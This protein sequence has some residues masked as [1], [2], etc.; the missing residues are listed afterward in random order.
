MQP[1]FK[2]IAGLEGRY[3]ASSDG[4]IWSYKS[5]RFLKP[6]KI[7]RG[8]DAVSLPVGPEGKQIRQYVH[9]LVARA[10]LPNLEGKAEVNHINGVKTDNRAA[11]L[12]WVTRRENIAHAVS[13]GLSKVMGEDNPMAKLDE[14]RVAEIRERYFNG[15]ETQ[16]ELGVAFGVHRVLIKKIVTGAIWP[17]NWKAEYNLPPGWKTK[18]QVAKNSRYDHALATVIRQRYAE[19]GCTHRGLA[20]E[21][22]LPHPTINLIVNGRDWTTKYPLTV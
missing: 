17:L 4:R 1:K 11:N 5:E 13:T 8:Y 22:G 18:L 14:M 10:F 15:P 20:K 3:A 12:E 21:F 16:D 6:A 2:D 9:R 19:G 7:G